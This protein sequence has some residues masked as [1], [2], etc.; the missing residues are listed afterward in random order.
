MLDPVQQLPKDVR[1]RARSFFLEHRTR[2]PVDLCGVRV[3]SLK[4]GL[5]VPRELSSLALAVPQPDDGDLHRFVRPHVESRGLKVVGEEDGL[6]RSRRAIGVALFSAGEDARRSVGPAL[7]R[8][9]G[10]D[11]E[12]FKRRG[13]LGLLSRQVWS[14]GKRAVA[15]W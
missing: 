12:L 4:R 1:E 7:E 15:R 2:Y 6:A 11:V 10:H 14:R 8:R 3:D 13:R 9:L 5:D